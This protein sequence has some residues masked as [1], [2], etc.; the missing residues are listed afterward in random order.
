MHLKNIKKKAVMFSMAAVLGATGVSGAV[1][2]PG[3]NTPQIAKAAVKNYKI[4]LKKGKSI[5]LSDIVSNSVLK[6]TRLSMVSIS[7][8]RIVDYAPIADGVKD[9]DGEI[10]C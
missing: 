8:D 3:T 5:E 4:T 6:K 2:M 1:T 10:V 9:I 7:N